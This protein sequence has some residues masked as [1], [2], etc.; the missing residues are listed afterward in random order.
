MALTQPID[1]LAKEALLALFD[2]V[3]P[4]HYLEPLKAPGPGYEVL[5]A[6]AALFARVS[7]AM[8]RL[9]KQSLILTAT[10]GARAEGVVELYRPSPNA[11]AITVV[12]KAGTRVKTSKG[13]RTFE[14]L[15]DVSFAPAD[16][17]PF[18]VAVR[19]V[20]E[21]PEWN[22]PGALLARDGTPLEGEI[23][24]ID[25][26]VEDPPLGDVTVRVRQTAVACSGGVDAGLDQ[27]GADRGIL[28]SSGEGDEPYRARIRALPDNIS[29]TAVERALILLSASHPV[30]YDFIETWSVEFQ[31]CWDAPP[32]PIAGSNYNPDLFAFDDPRDSVPFRNRWLDENNHRGAFVVVLSALPAMAD[33][34]FAWDAPDASAADLPT[35]AGT[36]SIGAWDVPA[37]FALGPVGVFDG[38]DLPRRAVYKGV[39]DTMQSIKAAGIVAAVELEGE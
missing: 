25:W 33:R 10:G 19:A 3:L 26:L 7:E 32:A 27:Q 14:T 2:R 37:A 22:V 11:E 38:F 6:W 13:G 35:T 36:R 9:G 5:Q 21:G 16:L 1:P 24:T 18:Q 23:D 29:P 39:W 17:G 30:A 34:G 20:A 4:A 28:R 15:A 8:A 31:S 12:V